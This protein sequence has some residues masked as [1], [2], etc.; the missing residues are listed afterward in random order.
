MITHE[1]HVIGTLARS[2]ESVP[3]S[4]DR[5]STLWSELM[6]GEL[7]IADAFAAGQRSSLVLQVRA[8]PAPPLG[9]R[10]REILEQTLLGGSGKVIAYEMNVSPSTVALALKD[11]LENLGLHC[12]PSRVPSSL[13]TLAHAACIASEPHGTFIGHAELGRRR[14]TV[15][16]HVFDDALLRKLPPSQR[17]VVSLLARGRSSVDI[18][19]RR[20]RSCRTVTNQIAAACRQLGV[21]GRLELLRLFATWTREPRHP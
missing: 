8:A 17:A 7:A 1:Q 5:C 11:S 6:S 4:V 16:T 18:A 10:A 9:A 19:A 12:R 13:V 20:N 2:V 3:A 21:C 14:I 15:V